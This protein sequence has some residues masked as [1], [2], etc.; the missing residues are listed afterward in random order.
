MEERGRGIEQEDK[1]LGRTLSH[2]RICTVYPET[3][4]Q[5]DTSEKRILGVRLCSRPHHRPLQN[6]KSNEINKFSIIF[7]NIFKQYQTLKGEY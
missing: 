5:A 2:Q 7:Y 1:T 6:N 3:I 4:D